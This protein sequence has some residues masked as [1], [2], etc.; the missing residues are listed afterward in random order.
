[1]ETSPTAF[2]ESSRRADE[3][4]HDGSFSPGNVFFQYNRLDVFVHLLA[5]EH[6]AGA[7]G[8]S[9][10][11]SA[12]EWVSLSD[13]FARQDNEPTVATLAAELLTSPSAELNVTFASGGQLVRGA[14]AAAAS[15]Y[16][17]RPV[18]RHEGADKVLDRSA[19]GLQAKGWSLDQVHRV[20]IEWAR[21]DKHAEVVLIDLDAKGADEAIHEFSCRYAV[22]YEDIEHISETDTAALGSVGSGSTQIL[23]LRATGPHFADALA[24]HEQAIRRTGV[25]VTAVSAL[26]TL[27]GVDRVESTSPLHAQRLRKMRRQ[28]LTAQFLERTL[29]R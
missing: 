17:Q 3:G 4:F 28:E 24:R 23:C 11:S 26:S 8:S 18:I 15:I 2:P 21:H 27:W 9:N 19:Q 10:D 20:L 22:M 14:S 1:M 6:L 16:G 5:F 25:D 13:A 12:I 7:E 29:G